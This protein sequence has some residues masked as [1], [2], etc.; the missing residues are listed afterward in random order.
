MSSSLL[1]DYE[2]SCGPWFEALVT[3]VPGA[4]LVSGWGWVE[5]TVWCSVTHASSDTELGEAASDS[6]I[7][8][9]W[10]HKAV[11]CY[12]GWYLAGAGDSV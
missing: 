10:T 3:A 7:N 8:R 9:A 1:R 2:P 12:V 5:Q 11:S 4:R 6:S